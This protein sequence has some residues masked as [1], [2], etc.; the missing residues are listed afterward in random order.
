MKCICTLERW[1]H[2]VSTLALLDMDGRVFWAVAETIIGAGERR[3]RY[4]IRRIGTNNSVP[5]ARERDIQTVRYS[6]SLFP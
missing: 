2:M 1:E 5:S 4:L 6:E 3:V